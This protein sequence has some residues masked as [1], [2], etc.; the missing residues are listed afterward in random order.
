M[1][2]EMVTDFPD[3]KV[4]IHFLTYWINLLFLSIVASSMTSESWFRFHTHASTHLCLHYLLKKCW[5]VPS[6]VSKSQNLLI[7]FTT[8]SDLW[9]I[10]YYI[11]NSNFSTCI[12]HLAAFIM[13]TTRFCNIVTIVLPSIVTK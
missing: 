9:S 5:G 12:S 2:G 1:A 11:F 4:K 10:C 13:I 7:M 3:K 6:E 8:N